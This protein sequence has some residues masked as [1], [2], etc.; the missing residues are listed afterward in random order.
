MEAKFIVHPAAIVSYAQRSWEFTYQTLWYRYLLDEEEIEMCK[1]DL[2]LMYKS[3]S[4]E[5]FCNEALT[6]FSA[7]CIQVKELESRMD[8][9]KQELFMLMKELISSLMKKQKLVEDSYLLKESQL[10]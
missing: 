1:G 10:V 9:S 3:L 8:V 4:I 7:Y 6:C 5:G 2:S